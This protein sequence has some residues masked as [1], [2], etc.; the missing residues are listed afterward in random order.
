[1]I[2]RREFMAG[3]GSLLA[4]PVLPVIPRPTYVRIDLAGNKYIWVKLAPHHHSG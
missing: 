1:M 2:A 4:A 3:L